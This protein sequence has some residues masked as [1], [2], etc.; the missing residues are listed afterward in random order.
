M[1][2]RSLVLLLAGCATEPYF[3]DSV[4]EALCGRLAACDARAFATD[5]TSA[6]ACRSSVRSSMAFFDAE[7]EGRRCAFDPA[8]AQACLDGI[9][10]STCE[11]L[12][13]AEV[14]GACGASWGCPEL[15]E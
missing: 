8:I 14:L 15:E 9:R 11:D 13:A 6:P 4:A 12:D 1:K 7:A 5:W 2:L 10:R 3:G